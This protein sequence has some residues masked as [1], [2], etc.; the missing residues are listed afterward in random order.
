MLYI[1]TSH[2]TYATLRAETDG[3]SLSGPVVRDEEA[4]ALAYLQAVILEG[5]R[6]HPP[7]EGLLPKLTP[8]EGDTI[9][10]IFVPGGTEIASNE[11]LQ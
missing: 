10:G 5:I 3:A 8:P 6:M 9:N 11:R 7:V 4:R 2:K 1:I